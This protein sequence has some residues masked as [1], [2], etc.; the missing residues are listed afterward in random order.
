M[1]SC[2]VAPNFKGFLL[3]LESA[4]CWD[5]PLTNFEVLYPRKEIL[6]IVEIDQIERIILLMEEILHQLIGFDM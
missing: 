1:F 2:Y 6:R 3:R 4:G 5:S